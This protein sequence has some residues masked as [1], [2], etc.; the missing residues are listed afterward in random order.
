MLSL[1]RFLAHLL[2][3]FSYVQICIRQ[4]PSQTMSIVDIGCGEGHIMKVMPG[5]I[6]GVGIDVY[7]DYVKTCSLNKT[8]SSSILADIRFLPLKPKTFDAVLC[9]YTLEHIEKSDGRKLLGFLEKIAKETIIISTPVSFHPIRHKEYRDE[10]EDYLQLHKSFWDPEEFQGR[11]CKV[12]GYTF[13]LPFRD[14]ILTS[15]FDF[16]KILYEA[17][18]SLLSPLVYFSPRNAD[19]MVSA[20]N[21]A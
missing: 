15:R 9:L 1:V 2:F 10:F 20:K 4:L 13:H 21:I 12:L 11:G 5:T 6:L 8:Y 17:A 16:L 19:Y 3:P 14:R 18:A 7:R